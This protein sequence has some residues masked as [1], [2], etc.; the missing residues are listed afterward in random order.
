MI[1]APFTGFTEDG[2]VDVQ[3]VYYQQKYYK[4]NGI[5]GA[6]VCGTTGEGSALTI[7]E[8]KTL[9]KKWSEY[10]E[11]GFVII[12][13]LGGT[14]VQECKE[15]AVYAQEVGL[16]AVAVTAPYYQ[17]AA[18]V[19]DLALSVADIASGVPDMPLF[20]YHIPSLTNV[21]FSMYSFIQEISG[22][23][24]N[25][26]GL[27]FTDYDMLDYQLCLNYK[28]RKYCVLWGRDE[29]FLEALAIGTEGFVG[30]TYGYNTPIYSA[31]IDAFRSGKME[32]AAELQYEA[33]KIIALLGKYGNGTGKAFM[34]AADMDLG[35]TRRPLHTL[36]KAEYEAFEKD[37]ETTVFHQYKCIRK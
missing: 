35:P 8:K 10:K 24:P 18:S 2:A 32:K 4:E 3:K 28:Q 23:S 20:Y 31:I 37:L 36:T 16:D 12:G 15:L 5:S 30:S 25:F 19:H 1:V 22:M 9:F 33:N 11:P 27:K 29:M 34:K 13:F 26:A 21:R 6:F 17:K 14:S 7:E